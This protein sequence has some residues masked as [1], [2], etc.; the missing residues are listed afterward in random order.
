ML[1]SQACRRSLNIPASMI[2]DAVY[3]EIDAG[4]LIEDDFPKAEY[5]YLTRL[6][7]AEKHIGGNFI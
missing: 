3:L 5:L 7:H 4:K 6:Y 1:V 2:S